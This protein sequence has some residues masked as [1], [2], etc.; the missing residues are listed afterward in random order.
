MVGPMSCK[1]LNMRP[2]EFLLACQPF[3]GSRED[4]YELQ[5]FC[6]EQLCIQ[7]E[8][9]YLY[10]ALSSYMEMHQGIGFFQETCESPIVYL[11]YDPN[12]L[13]KLDSLDIDLFVETHESFLE[14]KPYIIWREDETLYIENYE[15]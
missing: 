11:Y 8:K 3:V 15:T 2:T 12:D 1:A 13:S 14:K 5:D 4:I 9:E 7:R 6:V 10:N